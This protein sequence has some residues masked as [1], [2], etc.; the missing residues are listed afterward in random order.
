MVF[1]KRRKRSKKK[2]TRR[3]RAGG[4]VGLFM[5]CVADEC[6]NNLICNDGSVDVLGLKD[7]MVQ[8]FSLYEKLEMPN[9]ETVIDNLRS[10]RDNDS[11]A[12]LGDDGLTD[13]ERLA[14]SREERKKKKQRIKTKKLCYKKSKKGQM[15]AFAKKN[16]GPHLPVKRKSYKNC[17][18]FCVEGH[19]K[20]PCKGNVDYATIIKSPI[21]ERR[22]EK[23]KESDDKE[24]KKAQNRRE[25]ACQE[26]KSDEELKEAEE[27]RKKKEEEVVADGDVVAEGDVVADGGED[28]N[29]GKRTRKKRGGKRTRKKRGGVDKVCVPKYL[30]QGDSCVDGEMPCYPGYKCEGGTCSITDATM[31]SDRQAREDEETARVE[32]EQQRYREATAPKE[33]K[34]DLALVK[35]LMKTNLI[36]REGANLI[37]DLTG[38]QQF[39]DLALT[40]R[41]RMGD[42]Y[43]R[44][45]VVN[46][47]SRRFGGKRRTKRRKRRRK[48]RTKK[49]RRRRR[50]KSRK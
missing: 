12:G 11:T 50:R 7:K 37:G 14:Q 25:C 49:K 46:S 13:E 15:N 4:D 40:D 48:K 29:G 33:S 24:V 38:N 18:M 28:Q 39:G 22:L 20:Y 1:S 36:R 31:A 8:N 27:R 35:G 9:W 21:V 2:R 34:G 3:K 32:A 6:G 17:K 26:W 42:K 44:T 30:V 5:P 23:L 45:Q 10:I 16:W 43:G 47:G 41:Q 19:S